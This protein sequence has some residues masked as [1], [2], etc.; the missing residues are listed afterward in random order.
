MTWTTTKPT[1]PG[2]YWWRD[3]EDL[4]DAGNSIV[5]ISNINNRLKAMF[6][7]G[8]SLELDKIMGEYEW[9]GPLEPPEEET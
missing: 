8:W 4:E 6:I 7:D 2:W 3:P 5:M 1:V 9:A